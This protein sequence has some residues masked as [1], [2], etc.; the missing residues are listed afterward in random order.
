MVRL[1]THNVWDKDD[2]S[3]LWQEKGKD[4]SARARLHGIL[5]VYK[6]TLPDV[7]GCQEVSSLMAELLK[8][9]TKYAFIEGNYTPI[10]YNEE[11][12]EL[13]DNFFEIY[14]ENISGFEGTFND[15]QSKS[16]NIAVFRERK[17]GKVFAFANTHLWWKTS[18]ISKKGTHEYQPYSDE[19]REFQM[20]I[21]IERLNSVNKYN[22]PAI[23][24]GDFNTDYNSSVLKL[25]FK[26]G[27]KHAHDIATDKTDETMGYHYC[28]PDGY[29][30]FY[31]DKPFE[32]AIDHILLK[33]EKE[34]SVK[35]FG[36]YS[37]DYYLPISDHSPA[38]IDI[39]L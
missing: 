28:F 13:I 23:V 1:M 21:L 33:G 20:S 34:A 22:C 4:C 7:I 3:P 38:F 30:D 8:E 6:D 24:V 18:D 32:C 16:C 5:Q 15:S 25:L 12:L 26:N 14:P 2:N 35:V 9:N 39:E 37:P 17:S 36:R 31:Y 10:F 27:Y 19:A 29:E 11:K